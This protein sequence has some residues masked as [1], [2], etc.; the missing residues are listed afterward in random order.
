MVRDAA[1]T[2][3]FY[4]AMRQKPFSHALAHTSA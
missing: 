1:I 4:I 2:A 3:S